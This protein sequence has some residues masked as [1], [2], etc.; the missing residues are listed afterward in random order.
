LRTSSTPLEHLLTKVGEQMAFV[1]EGFAYP[2]LLSLARDRLSQRWAHST[3]RGLLQ[4]MPL[5]FAPLRRF[6]KSRASQVKLR[7]YADLDRYDLS[8]ELALD[9]FQGQDDLLIR[10]A[11]PGLNVR[12]TSF[13]REVTDQRGRLRL[14]PEITDFQ[15]RVMQATSKRPFETLTYNCHRQGERVRLIPHLGAGRPGARELA[16]QMASHWTQG[17][18]H[19]C[20]IVG[21]EDLSKML[22]NQGARIDFSSLSYTSPQGPPV[23]EARVPDLG[24]IHYQVGAPITREDTAETMWEMLRAYGVSM[25]GNKGRLVEKLARIRARVRTARRSDSGALS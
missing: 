2:Q 5:D 23:A 16:R 3:V 6:I 19:Y 25:S 11:L 8:R 12:L 22:S 18:R 4:A 9:D 14:I 20:F 21:L 10:Q 15:L 7:G 17:R 24:L 1:E 13:L